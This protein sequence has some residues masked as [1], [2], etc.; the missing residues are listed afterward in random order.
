M[1]PFDDELDSVSAPEDFPPTLK[2]LATLDA[3]LRCPI[4]KDFFSAPVLIHIPRCCHTFC[5]ACIRTCFNANSNSK[6]GSAGL[7]GVGNSQ[8]CPICKTEAHE[9]KIKPVPTLETAVANWQEARPDILKLV[10]QVGTLEGLLKNAPTAP[11][12]ESDGS[13]RAP[14]AS[15]SSRRP[16][17]I[18]RSSQRKLDINSE[19]SKQVSEDVHHSKKKKSGERRAS[20]RHY[21]SDSDVKLVAADPSNPAAMVPCPICDK[22]FRN[23]DMSSHVDRCLM[24]DT[25]PN[26][27]SQKSNARNLSGKARAVSHVPEDKIPLPH[28]PSLKAKDFKALLIQHDLSID[29]TPEAMTRRLNRYIL[30]HNANL[31][32]ERSH[33]KSLV[34]IRNE[35]REWERLQEADSAKRRK[36]AG[37]ATFVVEH[38]VGKRKMMIR[39]E[40]EYLERNKDQFA[41][42]T[43]KAAAGFSKTPTP[44][45]PEP[46]G[47]KNI[48]PEILDRSEQPMIESISE[49]TQSR[50]DDHQVTNVVDMY[51]VSNALDGQQSGNTINDH[52]PQ[53]QLDEL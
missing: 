29:G 53:S 17:S 45:Q 24:G 16:T 39:S 22:L 4:C 36:I 52:Q 41:L 51:P 46:E 6:I 11:E 42:L 10:S 15:C 12:D 19:S 34:D 23:S 2:S 35:V 32:A 9:E 25:K 28:F 13:T 33:R 21:S 7:G 31:D 38:V 43:A 5:S 49:I 48:T 27:V 8:R 18:T 50:L 30:L 26:S 47:L 40:V 37:E 44:S 14:E 3:T 20:K 1:R